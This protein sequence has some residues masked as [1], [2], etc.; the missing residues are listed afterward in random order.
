MKYPGSTLVVALL[1]AA[2][3]ACAPTLPTEQPQR[4]L[5]RDLQRVVDVRRGIG[6]L[7]DESEL[8]VVLPQGLKAVCQVPEADRAAALGWLDRAIAAEGGPDVARRWRERGRDLDEVADLLRLSRARLLL[9]RADEW[10]KQG[11]CPFW[12]EPSP[13]FRGVHVQD[14]R[15]IFTIEGGG[16]VTQEFALGS[17]RV[18]GGGSGRLLAGYG[19]GETW[20]LTTGFEFGGGAQF[21]NLQL[22]QQSELP[23]LV[24]QAVV[25]V[26][27]RWQFGLTAHA[28]LEAGPMAYVGRATANAATGAVAVH[29]NWGIHAGTA[30]GASYL[31]LQ[32]GFIPKFAVAFTIDHVPGVGAR[33]TLTQVGVGVR[34]GVDFSRWQRF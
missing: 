28:E 23:Q 8:H 33:P 9:Q 25:P 30:I 24:A 16:R 3:S 2:A 32:R 21:T 29:Y 10:V 4:A 27:L 15:F 13:R 5:V 31:R 20:A 14:Q 18:G 12:L 22:G 1:I 17:V 26:V 6:W 19:F 34:T 11:R 7:V